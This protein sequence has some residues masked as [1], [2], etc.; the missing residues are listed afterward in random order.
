MPN[1]TNYATEKERH[2]QRLFTHIARRYDLLN[3][4]ISFGQDRSWRRTLLAETKLQPG[5]AV[6]DVCC[7]TGKLTF[8]LAGYVGPTGR[9]AG[10][11]FC[12][13]M[14]QVAQERDRRDPHS[15]RIEW[16]QGNAMALPFSSAT[17]DAATIGFGLRNVPDILQV[18]QEMARVVK[19]GGKVIALEIAKPSAPLFKQ[20]FYLYFEH[21]L[22]LIGRLGSGFDWPYRWLPQ[23]LRALPEQQQICR[24]FEQ[25]GLLDVRCIERTGGIA[26]VYTGRKKEA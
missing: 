18:L 1:D 19:P 25:A 24:L 10:L 3:T 17:F 8:P 6:L 14:L 20:A 7:G 11:D 12:T 23:S 15:A 5:Q 16:H 4:I 2:V 21:L 22:P 9:A 26:A 13:E